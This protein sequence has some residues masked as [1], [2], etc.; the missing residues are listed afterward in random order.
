MLDRFDPLSTDFGGPF[1]SLRGLQTALA[2]AKTAAHA[3][4]NA[5]WDATYTGPDGV[6][7]D[8]HGLAVG[9]AGRRS[10]CGT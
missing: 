3:L 6:L 7:N 8:L 5:A 4:L 2:A 9:P 1:E 10:P